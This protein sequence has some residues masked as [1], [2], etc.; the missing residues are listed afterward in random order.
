MRWR[1]FL[2]WNNNNL[3]RKENGSRFKSPILLIKQGKDSIFVRADTLYSARLS[4]LLK[5][6]WLYQT[7]GEV[8]N[9]VS[10]ESVKIDGETMSDPYATISI[11]SEWILIEIGKKVTKKAKRVFL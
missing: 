4:D 8:K 11:W 2:N 6:V 9:A 10:W 1:V 7:T 5:D 3:I